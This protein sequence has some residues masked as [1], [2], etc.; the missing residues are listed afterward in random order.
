[1]LFRSRYIHMDGRKGAAS[2]MA[3]GLR[4]GSRVKAG[5]IISYVGNTG[6]AAGGPCH[7]HFEYHKGDAVS[8]PY[9]FLQQATIVQLDPANPLSANTATPQVSMTITGVIAWVAQSGGVGRLIIRP[10]G[11]STSDGT[12]VGHAGTIALRADPALL[13]ATS[14]GRKVTITTVPVQMTTALQDIAP[15]AWT[16]AS[17]A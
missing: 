7:L 3:K 9:A 5:Q 14:V 6:D 15:Y 10:S 16:A 4:D 2:A 1:M 12:R 11:V 17:I 13:D 8:S